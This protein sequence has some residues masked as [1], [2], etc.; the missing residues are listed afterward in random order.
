MVQIRGVL[1]RENYCR[2]LLSYWLARVR[3]KGNEGAP[4][5]IGIRLAQI[6]DTEGKNYASYTVY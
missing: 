4:L 6:Y 2:I 3:Q 1:T 5:E